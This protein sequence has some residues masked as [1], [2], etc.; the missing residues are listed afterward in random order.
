VARDLEDRGHAV[1]RTK[2]VDGAL[3]A[4]PQ[5]APCNV[6]GGVGT[7]RH[8]TVDRSRRSRTEVAAFR[9]FSPKRS[10]V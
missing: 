8:Q 4:R 1:H 3:V 5:H 10:R 6:V 9:A 7:G 2:L